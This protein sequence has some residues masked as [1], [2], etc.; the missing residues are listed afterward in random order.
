MIQIFHKTQE[1]KTALSDHN[2]IFMASEQD[3][4]PL[5]SVKLF[6]QDDIFLLNHKWYRCKQLGRG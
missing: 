2:R 4:T 6:L 5:A 3:S 1:E